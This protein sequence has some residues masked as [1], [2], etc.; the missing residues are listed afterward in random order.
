MRY[1]L[2]IF[3]VCCLFLVSC[4]EYMRYETVPQ[5]DGS[6]RVSASTA[7]MRNLS[8]HINI[9]RTDS[10]FVKDIEIKLLIPGET[11]IISKSY[12][13]ESYYEGE[14]GD[15]YWQPYYADSFDKLPSE[16]RLT[17]KLTRSGSV[18]VTFTTDFALEDKIDFKEFSADIEVILVD[19]KGEII[20]LKN[21]SDFKGQKKSVFSIH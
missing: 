1:I 20:T 16:N 3:S 2:F 6:V 15:I 10:L 14:N 17:N 18:P 11:R 4:H 9:N 8:L 7:G 21:R 5:K 12:E 13:M 19:V